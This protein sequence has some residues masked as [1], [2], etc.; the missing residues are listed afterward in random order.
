MLSTSTSA[1]TSAASSTTSTSSSSQPLYIKYPIS[2]QWE[3][4]LNNGETVKGEIYCTDPVA[5]LVILQDSTN[6]DIRMISVTSI[7][8]EKQTTGNKGSDIEEDATQK[9]AVAVAAKKVD[10]VHSKKVLDEREKRAIRLAQESLKHLNPKV[11]TIYL[12]D[13]LLYY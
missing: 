7:N 12:C 11:R 3:F 5:D 2:S 9:A 10:I 8:G 1:S 4:K 6:N 13:V